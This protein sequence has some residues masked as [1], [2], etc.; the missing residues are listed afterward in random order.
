MKNPNSQLRAI[1]DASGQNLA[2]L[3]NNDQASVQEG[4]I[5]AMEVLFSGEWTMKLVPRVFSAFKITAWRRPWQ[6]VGHLSPKILE[7]FDC[8]RMVCDWLTYGH[9]ICCLS[10]SSPRHHFERRED[11]GQA[12]GSLK[13]IRHEDFAVLGQF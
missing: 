11:P 2:N 13:G 10:E 6:T 8:F 1:L 7:N 4:D 5:L 3:K 12:A 9:V